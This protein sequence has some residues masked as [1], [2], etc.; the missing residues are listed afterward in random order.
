VFSVGGGEDNGS[1]GRDMLRPAGL[2]DNP[3][4]PRVSLAILL[5]SRRTLTIAS[6]LKVMCRK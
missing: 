3:A 2:D 4:F 5:S 6:S 1:F